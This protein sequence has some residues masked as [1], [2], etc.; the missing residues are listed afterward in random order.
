METREKKL[1]VIF[2]GSDTL[3]CTFLTAL[4]HA[5][6]MDVLA[7]VT[8]PDRE[9]G[10]RMQVMPGPVKE[11]ALMH[12][13]PVFSPEKVNEPSFLASL[14]ALNPDVIVVMAYGQFL[15]KTL[16]SLPRLGCVNLH[17]SILPRHRGAAP[18]QYAILKGDCETGVTAMLMDR[19][20][21]TGDILGIIKREIQSDDTTGTL[22]LSLSIAGSDLM[23]DVLRGLDRGE[24]VRVPQD[25]AFATYAPKISKEQ[26]L[27]EWSDSA[28]AIERQVRAFNPK[29][30][31][32]TFLPAVSHASGCETPG[33]LLKILRARVESGVPCGEGGEMPAPGTVIQMKGGPLIVTGCGQALRLLEVLPEGKPRAM[34]GADFS[35]GYAKKLHI[36]DRLFLGLRPEP[37][38]GS[39]SG[40]GSGGPTANF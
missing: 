30:G 1:R 5:P 9:R 2:M 39:E 15:G 4:V 14:E 28:E 17:V 12:C 23:L 32:H 24:I 22:G 6:D 19:G 16:L 10:R 11:L 3:S 37:E 35:N 25:A 34:A 18:I 36:G 7:V 31:C 27:I 40:P 29:P 26:G 33:P 38:S 13:K 8:Q 20:M 21:D